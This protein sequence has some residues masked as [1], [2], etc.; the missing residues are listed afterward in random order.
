[1]DGRSLKVGIIGAGDGGVLNFRTFVELGAETVA[2]CDSNL[3]QFQRMIGRLSGTIPCHYYAGVNF[4]TQHVCFYE[5]VEEMLE[6]HPEINLVVVATPDNKH[7]LVSEIALRRGK[8]VFLEKPVATTIKELLAFQDLCEAYPG[9]LIFSENHSFARPV[10]AALR[11][12]HRMG[13]FMVG[14]TWYVEGECDRLMGGGKWRTEHAY[15]PCAGGLSHHFMVMRLF[16]DS[17]ICRVRSDG[18][19]ITY[20]ELEKHGGFDTMRGTLEFESGRRL[21]WMICLA[22]RN[23][24]SLFGH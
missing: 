5:S 7:Y 2:V 24:A 3:K 1:M 11:E 17:P 15:N 6:N 19:V 16:T 4:L 10:E 8:N 23:K 21:D 22:I 18:E 9:K 20:K 14:N 12:R 13:S